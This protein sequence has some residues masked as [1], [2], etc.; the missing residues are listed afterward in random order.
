LAIDLG[1]VILGPG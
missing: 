1:A